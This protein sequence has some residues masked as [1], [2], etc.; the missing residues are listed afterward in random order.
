[1][2]SPPRDQDTLLL[3]YLRSTSECCPRCKFTL[4]GLTRPTCP[5]CGEGLRLRV[6]TNRLVLGWIILVM[7][8]CG[9]SVIATIM[10]GIPLLEELANPGIGNHI[11][12]EILLAEGFGIL[13][14]CFGLAIFLLRHRF[15]V[16]PEQ[17]QAGIAGLVWL[18]HIAV[19]MSL[20][21][22]L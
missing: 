20:F 3:E 11:Q 18:V 17:M 14:S 8:P 19:A 13:S 10:L 22:A 7:I 6:G 5:E 2:D 1:M 12:V 4:H 15:V 16:L 9:F 21:F